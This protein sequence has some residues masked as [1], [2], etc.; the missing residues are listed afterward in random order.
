[1]LC[2]S[3]RTAGRRAKAWVELEQ[4]EFKLE[5]EPEPEPQPEPQLEPELEPEPEPEQAAA[6]AG[7]ATASAGEGG[8]APN[9]GAVD[10]GG[11]LLQL[12]LEAGGAETAGIDD[13]RTSFSASS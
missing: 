2:S 11:Q 5:L 10:D 1:M 9:S 8:R 3:V 13:A 6:L 4:P 7:T 12:K